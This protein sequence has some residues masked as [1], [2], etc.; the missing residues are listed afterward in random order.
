[1]TELRRLERMESVLIE[2]R[3]EAVRKLAADIDIDVVAPLEIPGGGAVA[4]YSHFADYRV[5][6]IFA[7]VVLG[8]KFARTLTDARP[9]HFTDFD[10]AVPEL[11]KLLSFAEQGL[12]S[13]VV[14]KDVMTFRFCHPRVMSGYFRTLSK[15]GVEM[16]FADA[17][18]LNGLLRFGTYRP[19]SMAGG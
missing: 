4:V 15:A 10:R 1:M 14:F 18:P 13:A 2:R 11:T 12:I 9:V 8:D 16:H 19:G 7:Q 17:S 5:E 6:G 3:R